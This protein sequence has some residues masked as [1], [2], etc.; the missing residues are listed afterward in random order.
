M[1]VYSICTRVNVPVHCTSVIMSASVSK[2]QAKNN[3][4]TTSCI[5]RGSRTQASK[6]NPS[7][8]N[9]MYTVYN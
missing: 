5:E 1:Y 9:Q 2:F 6:G 4:D 3:H 7:S 8:V